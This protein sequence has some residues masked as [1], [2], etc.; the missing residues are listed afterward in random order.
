MNSPGSTQPG[1]EE[2]EKWLRDALNHLYDIGFLENHPLGDILVRPDQ[3]TGKRGPDLRKVLIAAIQARKPPRSTPLQSPDAR[4]YQILE[5]HILAGLSPAEVAQKLNISRSLFFLEKARIL[6]V[7]FDDLWDKRL[8][9]AE[10]SAPATPDEEPVDTEAAQLL[11]SAV[12]EVVEIRSLLDS[13]R[14]LIETLASA[15]STQATIRGTADV[16]IPSGDRVLLRQVLLSLI[17]ELLQLV[18]GGQ[19]E[20]FSF[21]QADIFQAGIFGIQIEAH[22]PEQERL[23]LRFEERRG[24]QPETAHALIRAMNGRLTIE[25][26]EDGAYRAVLAWMDPRRARRLLLIDDH[27]DIADLFT[28]QLTG[29]GGPAGS[30]WEITWASSAENARR[31]LQ[32]LRPE[33][34]VLDVILPLEDGWEFLI[35]LKADP[36]T[37]AIP[38]IVC[39][40]INEPDLVRSLGAQGYLPKPFSAAQVVQALDKFTPGFGKR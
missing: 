6:K 2:I 15:Q 8:V 7:I 20:I 36:L 13:L 37:R 19:I 21:I 24:L 40:A 14:P 22:K 34:I 5:Q 11:Q 35:A 27:P 1:R 3:S 33:V 25:V 28:R 9:P 32:N 39:S 23:E 16:V 30:N 10:Q 17:T 12:F 18:A 31:I 38:V 26:A 29:A 4:G